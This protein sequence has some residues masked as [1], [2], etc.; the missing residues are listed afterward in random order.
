MRTCNAFDRYRD[1]ELDPAQR[2]AFELHL[3]ICEDCRTKMA[4]LNKIVHILKQEE[5][6]PR[7]QADQI[8]RKAFI[9]GN[10]WDA[11][12]VSWLRPGP[13]MAALALVLVLFS[14]LWIIPSNQRINAYSEYQQLMDEADAINLGTNVSQLHNDSELVLWLE[15]EGHS[16]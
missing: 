12:V 4:L 16:R 15:L 7:D 13:A 11:L 2:S 6:R 1:G 9:V 10:S 14:F 8:A 5:I 3:A